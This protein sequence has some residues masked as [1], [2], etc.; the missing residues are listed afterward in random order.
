MPFTIS[1]AAAAIPFRR[2]RLVMSALV[3]GCFAPDLEYFLWL[4]PHGHLGHTLPGLVLF[5]L[6]AALVALF[7]FHRF[8]KAPLVACLPARLRERLR[9][10]DRVAMRSVSGFALICVSIVVGSITHILWD[11]LTHTEYWLGQHWSFLG[12]NV[13]VPLFG[14][15]D[16][17]AIF[18]YMS[19]ALGLVAIVIWFVQWYRKTPPVHQIHQ[20]AIDSRDRMVVAAAFL[21]AVLAGACGHRLT[22]CP[23]GV[24]GG[25]RFLTDASV[26]GITVFCVE[27][28]L[29]GFVHNHMQG[30]SEPSD[31][32]LVPLRERDRS[33]P[34]Q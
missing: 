21:M 1:H 12:V 23:N 20:A 11:S 9:K 31:D 17:A 3:F 26:T 2:T 29:Y 6:P 24:H 15:R 10:G 16:W 19:S 25:Q 14:R 34:R 13:H 22:V 4:R 30:A 7:L 8:A 28:L 27:I 18:Q 5:D 32:E 33:W